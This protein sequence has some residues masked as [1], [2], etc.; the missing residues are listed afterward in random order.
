M[1]S[2]QYNFS[3]SQIIIDVDENSIHLQSDDVKLYICSNCSTPR[4]SPA[5]VISDDCALLSP[6]ISAQSSRLP[7]SL[8]SLQRRPKP[9]RGVSANFPR[10]KPGVI[11]DRPELER[12]T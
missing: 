4:L 10:V 8:Q 9:S 12:Q 6:I 1:F 3:L 2:V 5:V 7:N 11:F